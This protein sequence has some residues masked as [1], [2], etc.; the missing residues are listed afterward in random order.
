M[1]QKILVSTLGFSLIASTALIPSQK[2]LAVSFSPPAESSAP[3]R[4]TGGASR[5]IFENDSAPRRSTGGASRTIFENDSA[6]RR[7]T[8][9]A[10]RTI[11]ENDSAPRRSTGGASR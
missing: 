1:R 4:S 6:P 3:R 10:S 11:F 8:G 2:A 5:T 9:G 7:S